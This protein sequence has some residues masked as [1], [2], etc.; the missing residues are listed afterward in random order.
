[1]RYSL[2]I[3]LFVVFSCLAE[4]S[5]L[6]VCDVEIKQ[7]GQNSLI[8][9]QKALYKSARKAFN[10]VINRDFREFS[11][12]AEY[13]STQQIQNCIYDYSIKHEKFSNSFYIADFLY[14]FSANKI[15]EVLNRFGANIKTSSREKSVHVGVYRDDYVNNAEALQQIG[16]E[17]VK[18]S[19]VRV[20]LKVFDLDQLKQLHINY[21]EL[22]EHKV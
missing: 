19:S 3:W 9:K 10:R 11:S 18:F 5:N 6:K 13:V 17:V 14:R 2:L 4:S 20:V 8:A 21:V 1:M 22:Q 7:A 15:A 16:A 12:Y